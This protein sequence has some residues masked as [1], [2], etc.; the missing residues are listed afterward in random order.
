MAVG[1]RMV[2]SP[3][4]AVPGMDT[5]TIGLELV[6]TVSIDDDDMGRA[7]DD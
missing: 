5:V 1:I 3:D 6:Q 7:S 2:P 4:L